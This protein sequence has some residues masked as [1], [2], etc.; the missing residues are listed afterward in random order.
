M[1]DQ[2]SP[3][4]V[5]EFTYILRDEAGEV[6]E[7]SDPASPVVVLQGQANVIRGLDA[8]LLNRSVGERFE[9]AVAPEQGYGPRREDWTQRISKKHF[10]A[11]GKLK[12]GMETVYKTEQGMR[13]V[14]VIKVG[15][16]MVDVDLNHPLAGRALN[17]EVE[18]L[19]VRDASP[20]EMAHGHA[21]GPG[22]HHH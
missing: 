17:F 4:S 7:R 16:K 20:N 15:M 13:R 11:A 8:A 2:I 19:S 18:I 22:G 12:A 21:H 1:P 10:A 5:V 3:N 6:L 14:T 9:V